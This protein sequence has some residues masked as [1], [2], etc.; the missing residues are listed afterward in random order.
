MNGR[1]IL[2]NRKTGESF[3]VESATSL[4][5]LDKPRLA[6]QNVFTKKADFSQVEDFIQ[7]IAVMLP[8]TISKVEKDKIL[9]KLRQVY[10]QKNQ[11]IAAMLNNPQA[12][13]K[14]INELNRQM[15]SKKSVKSNPTSIFGFLK[16]LGTSVVSAK[17]NTIFPGLALLASH[18]APAAAESDYTYFQGQ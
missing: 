16:I 18:I 7:Q 1:N 5:P 15:M 6:R 12:F 10:S 17:L 11:E 13:A 3:A 4:I 14:L 9:T 2:R 8:N